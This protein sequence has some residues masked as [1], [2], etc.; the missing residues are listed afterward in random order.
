[1]SDANT[2]TS[3]PERISRAGATQAAIDGGEAYRAGTPSTSCPHP[4]DGSVVQRFYALH[5]TRGWRGAS[6][7]DD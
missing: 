1:M 7:A 6:T 2:T 4:I 3:T 5:W